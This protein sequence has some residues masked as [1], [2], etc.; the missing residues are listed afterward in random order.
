MKPRTTILLLVAL[1]AL[2]AGYYLMLRSEEQRRLHHEEMKRV[3]TFE[4]GDLRTI[5]IQQEDRRPTVG[6]RDD[7]GVW[8]I[9]EPYALDAYQELWDRVAAHLAGL[10][11]ERT[12][13]E[14]PDTLDDYELDYPRLVVTAE[15]RNGETGK[16]AF[17][18]AG[19][20]QT[21][22]YAQINGGPV[23]LVDEDAYLELN[24]G[25]E[26]L[27]QFY[28][29]PAGQEGIRRVEFTW[30]WPDEED[31]RAG[32]PA[33]GDESTQVVIEV[34][35]DG[36]WWMREPIEC[37]AS[38]AEVTRFVTELQTETCKDFVD[39]PP[40]LADYGL[41]PPAARVTVYAGAGE[42]PQ[43]ALFG[44]LDGTGDDARMFAKRADAPA[45]F[46]VR[47]ELR[48]HFPESID[49]YRE[50]RLLTHPAG[51]ILSMRFTLR[52]ATFA[53]ENDPER[54]WIVV[55]PVVDDTDQAA[56]S[57][58][59]GTLAK[60]QGTSFPDPEEGDFG[61]DD[62]MVA[63]S[64]TFDGADE[65]GEIRVGGATANGKAYYVTQDAGAVVTL[66]AQY[67]SYI[68]DVSLFRFREK[69]LLTFEVED[70]VRAALEFDGVSYVF[71]KPAQSWRITEPDEKIWDSQAD[72]QALLEAVCPTNAQAIEAK[73]R[74]GDLSVYGLDAP[75]LTLA[76][77]VKTDDDPD[78]QTVLPILRIGAI[79][80][81]NSRERFAILDG[82]PEVFR[83]RQAHVDDIR[84]ALK[85]VRDR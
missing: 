25:L 51:S 41:D 6:V 49:A 22:R 60:L 42:N 72:M 46:T 70:V 39:E 37:P 75:T 21:N 47:K 67:T 73:L 50:R 54:G 53:L 29:F 68:T 1:C 28:L 13:E 63:L 14:D 44:S 4:P 55:E 83:V 40:S 2:C 81:D 74:P 16:V 35:P 23:G 66:D 8:R 45:V 69:K 10:M 26:M 65:P 20:L 30:F 18:M 80:K 84:Q 9:T 78:Q 33:P 11:D 82:R 36:R 59:I 71:E 15:T 31:S 17:G 76:L 64:L 5:S 61:L 43:T 7:Q 52:D 19:P 3:F 62:P 85:G 32:G 12:I 48:K 58:Y 34:E 77:T 24:R 79:A 27:R 56:V 57:N 38:I